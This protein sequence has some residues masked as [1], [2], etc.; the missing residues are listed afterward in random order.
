MQKPTTYENKRL[1][2]KQWSVQDRPR[3]KYARNGA[4][5]LSD[6]ELIA[7]LFRTGNPTESAVELAKQKGAFI[8]GICNAIGSSIP[9]ATD[10]GTYIHV[11]PEIGVASTSSRACATRTSCW[12]ASP[13]PSRKTPPSWARAT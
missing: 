6:A 8:Y 12:S 4:V 11:G 2:I 10:T 3:E 5:A 1:T 7:I 9:R 13:P